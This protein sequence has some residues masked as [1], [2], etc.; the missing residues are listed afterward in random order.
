[1]RSSE[2]ETGTRFKAPLIGEH[3]VEV[4]GEIGFSA[5]KLIALKEAGVI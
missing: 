4:Y 1:V 3:N 5:G 2:C